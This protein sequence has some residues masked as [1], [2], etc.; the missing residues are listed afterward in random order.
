MSRADRRPCSRNH[1]RNC[2]PF[3]LWSCIC[4]FTGC[5]SVILARLRSRPLN[6]RCA[7]VRNDIIACAFD[8]ARYGHVEDILDLHRLRSFTVAHA[9]SILALFADHGHEN[10]LKLCCEEWQLRIDRSHIQGLFRHSLI[11]RGRMSSSS[12]QQ[13]LRPFWSLADMGFS[14]WQGELMVRNSVIES[15]LING[16]LSSLGKHLSEEQH[17]FD[18]SRSAIAMAAENQQFSALCLLLDHMLV[19]T[20]THPTN[21][22]VWYYQHTLTDVLDSAVKHANHSDGTQQLWLHRV[23]DQRAHVWLPVGHPLLRRTLDIMDTNETDT[24]RRVDMKLLDGSRTTSCEDVFCTAV[25]YGRVHT[26]KG[27][28]A[29]VESRFGHTVQHWNRLFRQG[30]G[31]LMRSTEL[32]CIT[33]LPD[34]FDSLLSE[35]DSIAP[36]SFATLTTCGNAVARSDRLPLMRVCLARLNMMLMRNSEPSLLHLKTE[37]S[38][39]VVDNKS[40]SSTRWNADEMNEPDDNEYLE[41]YDFDPYAAGAPKRTMTQRIY[42]NWL[43]TSDS[44]DMLRLVGCQTACDIESIFAVLKT[45]TF[46]N[47]AVY[48]H[49]RQLLKD[50][51]VPKDDD[52]LKIAHLAYKN[53]NKNKRRRAQ[54]F[55]CS[56]LYVSNRR[57]KRLRANDPTAIRVS[58]AEVSCNW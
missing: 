3:D 44:L 4:E 5:P 58:Y 56:P 33:L 8:L 28:A 14:G 49:Y 16:D 43:M 12:P 1:W 55:D 45:R 10:A 27:Y 38:T 26:L 22:N 51:G 25:E 30:L 34:I 15:A 9:R 41:F 20:K 39:F 29:Q 46:P 17:H 11:E 31:R 32:P 19:K 21:M 52:R 6:T 47:R 7:Q 48:R 40:V 53:K 57:S 18:V 13:K 36:L 42:Y 24:A 54:D 50:R 2:L 37:K 23:L 35:L